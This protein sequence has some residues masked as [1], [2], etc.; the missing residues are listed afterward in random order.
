M[1]RCIKTICMALCLT[2]LLTLVLGNKSVGAVG[3]GCIKKKL[4]EYGDFIITEDNEIYD[5]SDQGLQKEYI[6]FPEKINGKDIKIYSKLS[7][8]NKFKY[9]DSVEKIF[10][11]KFDWRFTS[12]NLLEEYNEK[13]ETT[14]LSKNKEYIIKTQKCKMICNESNSA[15]IRSNYYANNY[16]LLSYVE[17]M[18]DLYMREGI[19]LYLSIKKEDYEKG[20]RK[21]MSSY[22]L[23]NIEFMYNY[24]D[25]PNQGHYW[26]DDLETGETLSYMP[27]DPTREGYTFGGWYADSE[28][29]TP[30]DF[31]IPY[32]KKDIEKGSTQEEYL[33][34]LENYPTYI[35]AKWIEN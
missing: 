20:D 25:A 12:Y 9:S 33:Y 3:S 5:F 17:K 8:Y 24:E 4:Y 23:A 18:D 16:S 6:I 14:I 2:M 32:L 10:Y 21:F 27:K 19:I 1:K 31:T 29:T 34:Y 30:Y 35:Y 13:W 7:I 15:L 28:C 26:I 11:Q 22:Y